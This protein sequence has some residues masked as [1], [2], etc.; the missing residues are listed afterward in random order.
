MIIEPAISQSKGERHVGGGRAGEKVGMTRRQRKS[1][2]LLQVFVKQLVYYILSG[3][4][5]LVERMFVNHT[6]FKVKHS[7]DF[8][9][10]VQITAGCNKLWNKV[11]LD[12]AMRETG[13]LGQE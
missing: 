11:I 8:R 1:P 12:T 7:K 9:V 4:K 3:G 5:M 10:Y 2:F 6:H 13:Q